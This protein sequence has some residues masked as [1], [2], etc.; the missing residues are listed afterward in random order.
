[1]YRVQF[2]NLPLDERR[3]TGTSALSETELGVTFLPVNLQNSEW[4]CIGY[5]LLNHLLTSGEQL[6]HQHCLRLN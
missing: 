5:I 1:M 3:A 6:G 2:T 4:V